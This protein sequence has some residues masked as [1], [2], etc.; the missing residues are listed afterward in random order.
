MSW[1]C[2]GKA[3]LRNMG[4]HPGRRGVTLPELMIAM[5]IM[6]M[7]MGVI[8]AIYFSS[9][10]VWRRCSAQSQADP[11]AHISLDRITTELKNA[12]R[13]D[14]PDTATNYI[15]FTLPLRDSTDTVIYPFQGWRRM[16]YYLSDDTGSHTHTGTCLWR[17]RTDLLHNLTTRACIAQNVQ[18]LTFQVYPSG[19]GR[20]L[21]VYAMAIAILG[22]EQHTQYTSSFSATVAFRN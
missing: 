1:S 9:L 18:S 10:A 11:P 3:M 12:Y 21:K 5:V 16:N 4:T 13:V 20:M 8:G 22:Q 19:S 6:T 2:E 15:T 17:E 7:V 14:S